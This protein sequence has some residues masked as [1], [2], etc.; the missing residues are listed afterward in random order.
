M[1]IQGDFR[2]IAF[3]I[4]KRFNKRT[5][6]LFPVRS[7]PINTIIDKFSMVLLSAYKSS[8]SN[9]GFLFDFI[10]GSVT[11]VSAS[12]GI[13]FHGARIAD[14]N[15]RVSTANCLGTIVTSVS[16]SSV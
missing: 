13:E 4:S 2:I 8:L 10:A 6:S 7:W 16:A 12:D 1:K 14:L 15:R 5:I 3:V 11:S 9:C